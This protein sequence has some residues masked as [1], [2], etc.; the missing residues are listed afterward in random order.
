M[1]NSFR[2]RLIG[3]LAIESLA[4]DPERIDEL[5]AYVCS[6]RVAASGAVRKMHAEYRR[7]HPDAPD[8]E[9]WA[10]AE[11]LDDVMEA[12]PWHSA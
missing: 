4:Y 3:D 12:A 2:P 9:C 10:E 1:A 11:R 6:L 5:I 8:G 7:E